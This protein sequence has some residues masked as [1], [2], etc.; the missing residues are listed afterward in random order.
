MMNTHV[1][2]LDTEISRHIW[3][4]RYRWVQAGQIR[5]N[6][7]EDTWSRVAA[8]A[9]S[10]EKQRAEFWHKQFFELLSSLRFLPGGRILAG[11]G[12]D[13][14]VT[15][16][17]CFVMGVIG[18][19][20]AGIFD[21]LK[22]G[23]LTMQA[24]GGVGYD[25]STLRPRGWP[26]RSS[27]NIASGPVS[28]MHVWNSM[29]RT[30]LS[31][32]ARRG[33]MIAS[34]RCD[35]PDVELFI[36]A[37]RRPG[38]LS[39]FNLSL[40]ISDAFMHA[41]QAGQDWPLVFPAHAI[42][43]SQ[44]HEIVMRSWPGAAEAVPCAVLG[45]LPARRLWQRLMQ[46]NYDMA[47]PGVLFVD[48]INAMNNLAW[49]ERISC[50]NPCGE[51]PLPP[52]GA[53]NLGSI[54]LTCFVSEPF[55]AAARVDLAAIAAAVAVA[56]RLLDNIIDC[57][58]F[59]LQRQAEQARGSRRIGL[60]ITGLADALIMAGLHYASPAAREQ[61]AAIMATV[62]HAAYR[63]SVGLAAEKGPFPFFDRRHYLASGF[64][65]AMP[66]DI[67]EAIAA[68]GIRNSHLTAI[69][70]TGT[71]SLLAGNI[72]SGMEPVFD[73]RP[74]RRVL[75]AQ[76]RCQDF[77][78]ED[79]AYRLWREQGHAG[80]DLPDYFVT[81][82]AVSAGAQLQMQGALQPFVDNAISKT[83]TV[84]QDCPF[85]Q[86]Q[87]LY[88]LAWRQGLKGCTTF[89]QG[90]ERGAVVSAGNDPGQPVASRC[91]PGL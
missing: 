12:T 1:P 39:H 46:A 58:R 48:R 17:N 45:Q 70:P 74:L 14:N 26:A 2:G 71:I 80:T 18:D 11:A 9:A 37:K 29:C 63:C 32:G 6:T 7:I 90:T 20:M 87:E 5:D 10:V 56:T 84:P 89:R 67:T 41:V 75:D 24:G 8:A 38:D 59:P 69:A 36:D 78:L 35:H 15:L 72:S 34:L 83:I 44:R 47:E 43:N 77:E 81:A 51:V 55:T 76:G 68:N 27:G 19:D 22:E 33:A 28:Y 61:A 21:G 53:C 50:T 31:T 30:L 60:G 52:Y 62:C 82:E 73:F 40:Q 25:F 49:R 64:L 85:D 66:A 4:S 54:N 23:A 3:A 42:G 65:R 86:F 79:Y 91:C 57:S 16:F 13:L 88:Q